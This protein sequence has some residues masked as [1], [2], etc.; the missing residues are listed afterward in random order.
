MR[1]KERYTAHGPETTGSDIGLLAAES[2]DGYL[3]PIPRYLLHCRHLPN[4]GALWRHRAG[5]V[6]RRQTGS[7]THWWHRSCHISRR[8]TKSEAASASAKNYEPV[9]R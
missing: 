2:P 4:R 8:R 1:E 5:S 9:P 7:K 6:E 3:T